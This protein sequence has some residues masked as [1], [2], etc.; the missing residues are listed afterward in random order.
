[1]RWTLAVFFAVVL[2]LAEGKAVPDV[3]NGQANSQ[4]SLADYINEAQ[5]RIS[6][7]GTKIQEHLNLP[8]QGEIL[9]TIKEH[10]NT[11]ANNVRDYIGNMTAEVSE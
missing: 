4:P 6:D 9:D 8:K 11:F 10:S 2:V 3:E 7:L 5:T 1:M